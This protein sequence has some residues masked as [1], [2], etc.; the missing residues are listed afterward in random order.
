MGGYRYDLSARLAHLAA[1]VIWVVAATGTTLGQQPQPQTPG[2]P[3]PATASIVGRLL[4]ATTGQPIVRGVVVLR[5]LAS[6]DQRVVNTSD[7]GEFVLVDLPAA[8]YSLH[9]SA[10][11]YVGRQYGQRHVLGEG[12]PIALRAGETRRGVDVALLPGGAITG[13]VT[14]QDG[15]LLAFAEVEAL[16]PQLESSL[17]VLIPVGRAETNERGEFRIVGLPPG[18]YYVA[19]IDPADEGTE[20]ATGQIHWAQ[21]FYPGTASAAAAQRVRLAS[22]ATLTAVDFPLRGVSR[23]SVRGRLINPDES[24][25]ATGSVTMSPESVEGLG[26]GTGQAA[27]VRPDGTFEFSNVSPGDYRLRASARTVRAGP[28][29]FASFHLEVQNEDISNA[30]LFFNRGANLF[31]QVEITGSGTQPP[32]VLTDL[33]VSAPMAD[34]S[35]GSGLTRSQVRG[36]GSFSLAS[37]EGNRVIRLEGLPDPWSLEAVLYQGRNV[38]DVPFDLRSGQER[39]RIRLI[40]TDRASRLVG[41]VQDEDG[42]AITE[43]AIVALP[44]NSAYWRPGSRHI[45]LTYPDTSGRYEIVGLPAGVYLVAAIAGI[46]AG[47]PY[48]LAIFQEIA[49]AG[50]EALVEAGETTTLDLVLTL[51]RNRLAN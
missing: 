13:R 46:S 14:T 49:A 2:A 35:M 3:E 20:D 5:E 45:Q 6:R 50:T 29:L 26:L 33:W 19:A 27:L 1:G 17:R 44:V 21:T 40:L 18:H 51:E 16:R 8:T 31:G 25:L 37:P 39:E 9:A 7:T 32:P 47:D 15:Q 4:D 30:V 10:L 41:V 23:V 43:R 36:N 11:G 34:G 22:G 28:A 42:N 48:D 38:I 24:E 12:L